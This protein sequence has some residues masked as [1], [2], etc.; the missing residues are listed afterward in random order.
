MEES[1]G[2]KIAAALGYLSPEDFK[3]VLEYES[4]VPLWESGME[5]ASHGLREL[6]NPG[7]KARKIMKNLH[8]KGLVQD[9]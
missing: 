7:E 3:A 9:G 1:L 6:E 2:I 5:A 8:R 4:P